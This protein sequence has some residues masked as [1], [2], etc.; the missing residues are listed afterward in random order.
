[1]R[2]SLLALI[3]FVIAVVAL[4][5]NFIGAAAGCDDRCSDN[6]PNWLF[7]GSAWTVLLAVAGLLTIG[8]VAVVRRAR[9]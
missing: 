3:L 1:V 7:S 4:F 5:F 8:V 6:F 2:L 9:R